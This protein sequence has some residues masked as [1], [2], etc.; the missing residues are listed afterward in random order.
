MVWSSCQMVS[1]LLCWDSTALSLPHGPWFRRVY[2]E[3][4]HQELY[5]MCI[6]SKAYNIVGIISDHTDR[7]ARS[8]LISTQVWGLRRSP[9][10]LW[11]QW[12]SHGKQ[13]AEWE[14]VQEGHDVFLRKGA[15]NRNTHSLLRLLAW[16]IPFSTK[17]PRGIIQ[18]KIT[19]GYEC[20][21]NQ[22]RL[23]RSRS[24]LE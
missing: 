21:F 12:S 13:P 15:Q 11:K 20:R 3:C 14:W 17:E 23:Q 1:T 16:P 9:I 2:S 6:C 22:Y 19:H 8:E 10:L 18:K 7:T 4:D 5:G 24:L